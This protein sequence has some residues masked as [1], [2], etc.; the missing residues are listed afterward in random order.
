MGQETISGSESVSAVRR[1]SHRARGYCG[2]GD[3]KSR[4]RT[5][6][7]EG[8]AEGEQLESNILQVGPHNP[9]DY[10]QYSL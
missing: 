2:F 10:A 5:F 9:L 1:F 8:L 4:Q 7:E 6:V 3:L